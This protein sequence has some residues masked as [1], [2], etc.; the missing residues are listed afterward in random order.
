M[1]AKAPAICSIF[2]LV[3]TACATNPLPT[4]EIRPIQSGRGPKDSGTIY[5]L[6]QNEQWDQI[7][8]QRLI[9]PEDVAFFGSTIYRSLEGYAYSPDTPAATSL[10]PDLATDQ[11]SHNASAT[12]WSFTLRD[13][14]TWQDGSPVTCEDVKYGV[15]RTFATDVINQ[16]PTYAIAYLDIPTLKDGTSAY[17]GPYK[18]TGQDLYDKAVTCDGSKV[19]F[20]LNKPVPDF[21]FTVTLAF[22]PVRQ[23]DDTGETYGQPG[24][25][26]VSDGPYMVQS[27]AT[28]NGGKMVLVRNP[29]WDP[30]SDPY[31]PAYPDKWEVDFGID[32]KVMDQR[33]MASAGNDQFAIQY[34]NIQPENM[35]TIFSSTEQT[36]TK[37]NGIADSSL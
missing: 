15:S 22:S 32:T 10:T 11:G 23:K 12:Q 25:L 9:T 2:L 33:L 6:T 19:T 28:G 29:K 16:G 13:G 35:A 21:N 30:K 27:Y 1:K 14:V 20:N 26:V 8:P 34:G 24:H 17:K 31:R 7:D 5:V 36:T 37:Y 4:P 3:L 18:K